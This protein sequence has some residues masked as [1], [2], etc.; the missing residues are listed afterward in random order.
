MTMEL[1]RTVLQV[2]SYNLCMYIIPPNF[3][4]SKPP[5][6]VSYYSYNHCKQCYTKQI[7][8]SLIFVY[9][10][11]T[12][13]CI[14]KPQV[15]VCLYILMHAVYRLFVQC[16]YETACSEIITNA[17]D[18]SFCCFVER[19]CF[20]DCQIETFIAFIFPLFPFPFF[21]FSLFQN[22]SPGFVQLK[23]TLQWL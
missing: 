7:L 18:S 9:V 15:P 3:N 2:H 17:W 22:R 6:I 12:G 14:L 20:W 19:Q 13:Y 16:G 5:F 1:S 23:Q 4:S 21:F 8:Q 11:C 10:Y